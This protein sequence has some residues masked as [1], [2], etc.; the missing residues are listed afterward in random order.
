MN[1]TVLFVSLTLV[2]TLL[3]GCG[4]SAQDAGVVE[5]PDTVEQSGSEVSAE[6]VEA[7]PTEFHWDDYPTRIQVAEG[8]I[9]DRVIAWKVELGKNAKV[10]RVI[11]GD[12]QMAMG[13]RIE[14][15]AYV[16]SD[17]DME[18]NTKIEL[19]YTMAT[20]TLYKGTDAK[21]VKH[22]SIIDADFLNMALEEASLVTSYS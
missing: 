17:L 9:L 5:Q 4:E 3:L 22:V 1:K 6:V 19:L 20:T 16:F 2:L 11:A 7:A 15:V 21:V 10:D 18:T 8:E 13:S 12:L 14:K